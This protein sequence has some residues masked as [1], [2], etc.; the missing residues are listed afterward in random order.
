MS[1]YFK[2]RDFFLVSGQI[3]RS[4]FRIILSDFGE[5][6]EVKFGDDADSLNANL[7]GKADYSY[8]PLKE[9]Y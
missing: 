5:G 3:F 1:K 2:T 4:D 8:C 9:L 7:E 6:G